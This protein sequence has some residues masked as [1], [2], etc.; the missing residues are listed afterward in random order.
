MGL[1]LERLFLTA[2][3]PRLSASY[4]AASCDALCGF[5]EQVA[6]S[7]I[8]GL[9]KEL[10][11]PTTLARAFNVY[12]QRSRDAQAKPMKHLLKV[13]VG[14]LVKDTAAEPITL[15]VQEIASNC[16][17]IIYVQDDS[18]CAK[19]AMQVL[20]IFIQKNLIYASFVLIVGLGLLSKNITGEERNLTDF[21]V[22]S[23]CDS[24]NPELTKDHV[25]VF[26]SKVMEWLQ[27]ADTASA[28]GRLLVIV[29]GS[30][31][32]E[33]RPSEPTSTSATRISGW[34]SSVLDA[35]RQQPNLAES[36]EQHLLP[37][38]LRLD[39]SENEDF[40]QALS[41]DK[42]VN[43]DVSGLS[44]ATVRL[45]LIAVTVIEELET[46]AILRKIQPVARI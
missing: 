9:Q 28:A 46:S 17:W 33:V 22:A 15:L 37:S 35:V 14:L 39:A 45:C 20:G 25:P 4:R 27:H 16:L 31:Q 8:V 13:L 29:L 24:K 23:G 38:L 43:G 41:I 7:S 6:A 32:K 36:L 3:E 10:L 21:I 12:I 34:V 5:F 40:L 18:S 26:V 42:I 2:E 44:E 30:L 1:L 19:A 11:S